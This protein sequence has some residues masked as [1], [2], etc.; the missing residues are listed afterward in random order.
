MCECV[1]AQVPLDVYVGRC[2]SMT[3]GVPT[4]RHIAGFMSGGKRYERKRMRTQGYTCSPL[5]SVRAKKKKRNRDSFRR[6]QLFGAIYLP[7]HH[8]DITLAS[9]ANSAHSVLEA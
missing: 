9:Q 7:T 8:L 4:H 3:F 6:C 5:Q 2:Y 1:R